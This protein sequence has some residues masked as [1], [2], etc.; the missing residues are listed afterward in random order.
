MAL[1]PV[2]IADWRAQVD[3]ELAGAAFDKAL[4]H[5]T[6]EGIAV[7]PLYVEAPAGAAAVR[8]PDSTPF[9]ICMRAD[10]ASLREDVDGGA[11][12]VWIDAGAVD[13]AINAFL[14]VDGSL[15]ALT[16]V[17]DRLRGR[18]FALAADPLAGGGGDL[19]GLARRVAEVA[20]GSTSVLVSTLRYH[21]AGADAVDE[22]AI[23]LSTGV[24]Y[25]GALLD[26]GLEL[27]AAAR[28][29]AVQIAVG[30]DTFVELAKLRA[31]RRVWQTMLTAAGAGDVPLRIHAVSASRTLTER[32]P[33]VN[34]LRVTTQVFAAVLGGADLVTPVTFDEALGPPSALGRRIARNT[35]LVL[36]EESYLGRVLDPAAGSYYL[37]TM[38]DELARRA[39]QRF[40][41]I[42]KDGGIA[43][44]L[45]NGSLAARLEAAWTKRA[46]AIA[47]RKEP[48][49]G[50]SEF[51]NL[52]EERL[53]RGAVPVATGLPQHRDAEAFEQLRTRAD[54]LSAEV[55]LLTLGPP[56]EHRGRAG[57][58]TAFFA[59]GGLRTHESA[60]VRP[61]P[62]AVICGSDERYATEAAAAARALKAAGARRVLLAGRPGALEADLR[63]AGVDGFIFVGADV[64][65][66][67]TEL[68]GG[69]S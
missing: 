31:L 20:P 5:T 10:A 27:S 22:L 35:A 17:V 13:A 58:S 52:D 67:L 51:A 64:V 56:A 30:R 50:V 40:R 49:T 7:Q 28:Q 47:R 66:I 62:V 6:A 23:A 8:R 25:L 18:R 37:E 9:A 53:P 11:D 43:A 19:A 14:V 26:G 46:G 48:I 1:P 65:A 63:E 3:K 57:F 4:V 29:I 2:T 54:G 68:L 38:T 33:W 55:L 12:A 59:A 60:E 41:E 69:L 16:G 24:A 45:A 32:D 36:R 21:A 44:V 15:A 39:W 61:A 42:E 34:I